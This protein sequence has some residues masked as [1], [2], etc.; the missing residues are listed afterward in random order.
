VTGI[1]HA[2][3]NMLNGLK[4]GAYVIR[5]GLARDDPERVQEGWD[6]LEHSVGQIGNYAHN[7]LDYAK[8]WKLELQAVDLNELVAKIGAANR[9][10]AADR[11][12]ALGW[13]CPPDLPTVTCDPRLVHQ[14]VTDIVVNAIDACTWKDYPVGE[15]PRVS[16][17]TNAIEGGRIFAIEVRDNGCGMS[18]EIRQNIFTPFFSTKKAWGTGLGLALTA[19]VIKAHGGEL[20]VE[21]EPDRGTSFR[22][23][24]PV[25][26]PKERKE[27][28]DGQAGSRGG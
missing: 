6:M 7:M 23:Q 25:K 13:E 11:G 27:T 16:V 4:G 20:T 17:T 2:I 12:V 9:Q 14:A 21:S 1:Q 10:A 5:S 26:G 8:E 24:L 15:S 3:K 19:R 22:I 18:E 28:D